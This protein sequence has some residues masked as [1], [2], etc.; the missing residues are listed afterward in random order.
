MV[1]VS[2]AVGMGV[3]VSFKVAPAPLVLASQSIRPWH[4]AE[5][6]AGV[7]WVGWRQLPHVGIPVEQAAATL[8]RH[9]VNPSVL[10]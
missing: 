3:G 7:S 1:W 5:H 4:P 2:G 10:N 6:A 9:S 8:V